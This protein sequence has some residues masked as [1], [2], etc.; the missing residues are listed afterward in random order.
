MEPE[1]L[2]CAQEGEQLKQAQRELAS[3]Q[4]MLHAVQEQ[5]THET[6]SVTTLQARS[7]ALEAQLRDTTDQNKSLKAALQ[8]CSPLRAS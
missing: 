7:A 4:Q 8:V 2:G 5:L 6:A 3:K 1:Q